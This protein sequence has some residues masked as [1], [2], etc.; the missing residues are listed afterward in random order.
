MN[1]NALEIAQIYAKA[2]A[3]KDVETIV[4][5]SAEDVVCSRYDFH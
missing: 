2:L 3:N 5:I 4:S 1:A